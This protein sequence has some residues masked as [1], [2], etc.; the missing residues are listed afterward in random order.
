MAHSRKTPAGLRIWLLTALWILHIPMKLAAA[1]SATA[2]SLP[3]NEILL[4]SE[5]ELFRLVGQAA[6]QADARIVP[7]Q[8]PG[9]DRAWR[10]EVRH[11]PQ[12]E[13]QVQLVSPV[14][15][16]LNAGDV[17]LLSAWVR[18]PDSSGPDQQGC[19]GL[20]LEQS[21]DPYDKALA[22]R[23]D[24][25]SAW[26]RLDVAATI[27]AGFGRVGAHVALR[28]GYFQQTVEI[29]GV[30]LRRFDSPLPLAALPQTPLT[31]RGRQSDAAW[32]SQADQR[33]ESLRKAP[34]AVRVTDS[35]GQTVSGAQIHVHMLRHA[36]AFGCAYNDSRFPADAVESTDD[37]AYQQHFTQLFNTGVDEAGMK[38]PNWVDPAV[39][40]S[41]LRALQWMRDHDIDVRGHCLIWPGWRHLPPDLRALAND[42]AAL[43]HRIEDH[44]H[45]EAGALAG[46]VVEWDVVNEPYLNNDLMHILG[47]DAL[48]NWFKVARQA[49]SSARL[50]L[51]ETNVP[52]SP[53]R[54]PR[55]DALYNRV[56]TLQ[57]QGIP[58][59]G[60]GM[61]AHFGDNL[62]APVDLLAIYDR[63]A[64]L[65]LPI[66]I[67]E[68][69]ID[70]ADEQL[71]A[72]YFRDFLTA[73][74]S[75]PQINGI[76]LWGFWAAQHW[77]PDAAL[78]RKDWS[79]KPNGQVWKDLVLGKWWTNAEG[80]S[81]DDGTFSMRGF[82]GDYEAIVTV[83]Q[84]TRTVEFSLPKGGRAVD[85][86]LK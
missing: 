30:E 14:P 77:R 17:V 78:Y 59:G 76:V 13:Y 69:D 31:Y 66:R 83:G 15:E 24:V 42:P 58:I 29:G 10:I 52:N 70:V 21:A 20:I 79:L 47:D 35:S 62:I 63:F 22:R 34:L 45:D 68:L 32:R 37:L 16:Q 55:Y 73:S 85:I 39:R 12:A 51:N 7:A 33:I 57:H 36:F 49:D 3:P 44:I 71:Q 38:W 1:E 25:G 54:D 41:T 27:K 64:T 18:A 75:H 26:Q 50:Y 72:D 19:V 53:P 11:Q 86:S 28:L 48:G 65:E 61:Q 46:Q 60:I 56:Q 23:F 82:L 8:G 80:V 43:E 2:P 4:N 84:R 74:F 6:G 9:F 67:T 81:A 5:P 40:R